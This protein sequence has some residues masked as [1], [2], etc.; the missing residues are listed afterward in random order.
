MITEDRARQ[1]FEGDKSKLFGYVVGA[2][3]VAAV[4]FYQM[5]MWGFII[6][7]I[8]VVA[9]FIIWGMIKNFPKD[10]EIDQSFMELKDMRVGESLNRLG[11]TSSDIVRE[12]LVVLGIINAQQKKQGDDKIWRFNPIE[13]EIIHFGNNQLFINGVELNLLAQSKY[14]GKTNEFFYKDISAVSI[15]DEADEKRFIIKVHG[16]IELNL[17]IEKNED[18][19]RVAESAVSAIRKVLREAKKD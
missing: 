10:S 17:S 11:I 16:E 6:G 5:S 18:S 13:A 12:P 9:M 7:G 1:Y 19:V 4:A 3:I 15:Q 14:V 8:A 2:I